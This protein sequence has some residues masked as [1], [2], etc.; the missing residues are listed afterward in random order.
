MKVRNTTSHTV[1]TKN[2]STTRTKQTTFCLLKMKSSST[3]WSRP[4]ATLIGV[5]GLFGFNQSP[6]IHLTIPV[7]IKS[8]VSRIRSKQVRI[9]KFKVIYGNINSTPPFI[10]PV[11]QTNVITASSDNGKKKSKYI[12]VGNGQENNLQ[13]RL[14]V[15][16]AH[17]TAQIKKAL[18]SAKS[19]QGCQ[20]LKSQT[21]HQT[22][23]RKQTR[24]RNRKRNQ[25]NN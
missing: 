25:N 23:S 17:N 10:L 4:F 15:C 18:R 7:V 19:G 3:N 21:E 24:G 2:T 6:F 11:N 13:A 9:K 5:S 16:W 1:Q 22:T 12:I 20:K 8:G 14:L